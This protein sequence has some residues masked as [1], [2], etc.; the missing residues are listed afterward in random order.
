LSPL[1]LVVEGEKWGLGV[2]GD[3]M[4]YLIIAAHFGGRKR[5]EKMVGR[6]IMSCDGREAVDKFNFL[7]IL[8]CLDLADECQLLSGGPGPHGSVAHEG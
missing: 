5:R 6:R 7:F 4:R 1:D 8:C 2:V 3:G